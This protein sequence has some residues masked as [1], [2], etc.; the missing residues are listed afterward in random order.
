M[1]RHE[2][3]ISMRHEGRFAENCNIK[4]GSI[5]VLYHFVSINAMY[6]MAK[7]FL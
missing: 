3:V 7:P 6:F 1:S 2:N 5:D 4:L